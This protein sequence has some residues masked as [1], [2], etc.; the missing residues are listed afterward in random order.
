MIATA[1]IH[2]SAATAV[3]RRGRKIPASPVSMMSANTWP[4]R[5]TMCWYSFI[6]N[7]YGDWSRVP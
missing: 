5:K 3:R 2:S 4:G 1:E 6:R 7:T